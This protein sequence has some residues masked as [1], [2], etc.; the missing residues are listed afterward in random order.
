MKKR[1]KEACCDPFFLKGIGTQAFEN[2]FDQSVSKP[3]AECAKSFFSRLSSGFGG[4]I[5][6]WPV[7]I[8]S[9][10][11]KK[12]SYFYGYVS[13]VRSLRNILGVILQLW[14]FEQFYWESSFYW[15]LKV[16][17]P[18]LTNQRAQLQRRENSAEAILW[19][20]F[21]GNYKLGLEGKLLG[22]TKKTLILLLINSL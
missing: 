12:V 16:M 3:R 18:F 7:T 11:S 4:C 15:L 5:V 21:L 17:W 19:E 22:G 14:N 10:D 8:N 1:N 2:E 13:W 6:L 20:A 9:Y